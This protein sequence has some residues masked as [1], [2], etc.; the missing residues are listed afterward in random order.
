MIV[1]TL[2]DLPG[3]RV[4]KV[5]G[6]ARGLTVRSRSAL[7]NLGGAIQ[8]IF[9]GALSVYTNLAEAARQEPYDI[10][11]SHASAMGANA[12]VALRYDANE[13]TDGI[14]EGLAYGTAVTVQA[15]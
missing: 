12:I 10:L 2:N 3:R 4:T 7:G 8:S 1:T 14:T 9:G 11:I 6:V 15:V 13:I 5:I